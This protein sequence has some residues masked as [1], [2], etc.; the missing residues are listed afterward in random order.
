[1]PPGC[2]AALWELHDSRMP[3]TP[4]RIR[5]V[6]RA[7]MGES[8]AAMAEVWH[9]ADA[10]AEANGPDKFTIPRK[11]ARRLA[12]KKS[13]I[14]R[15]PSGLTATTLEEASQIE[16]WANAFAEETFPDFE[17]TELTLNEAEVLV[18]TQPMPSHW[19]KIPTLYDEFEE[20][21]KHV[22]QDD[23][24]ALPSEK[25][26]EYERANPS[27][28]TP[29]YK[30]IRK[31]YRI[32][33]KGQRDTGKGDGFAI[34]LKQ[35]AK[36]FEQEMLDAYARNLPIKT[37]VI[38]RLDFIPIDP[39][40]S[41]KATECE[42]VIIRT[43]YR[44]SNL[45]RSYAWDDQ[46]ALLEPVDRYDGKDGDFYLYEIWAYD[47]MRRP[48]CGYQVGT[49]STTFREDGA[50]ATV[51]LW[52]EY[53]GI[54]ELPIAFEYGDHTASTDPDRR[55]LP[56]PYP[57]LQNWRQRD[58]MLTQLGVSVDQFAYP[59][60]GQLITKESIDVMNQLEGDVD[61]EFRFE[62]NTIKPIVGQ[63]VPLN[64]ASTT[65]DFRTLL[66]ALGEL[67]KEELPSAGAFGGD[68]PTSGLDRQLTGADTEVAYA[69]TIE[70]VR[71]VKEKHARN[72]L[73]V[74][75]AL[76]KKADRPVPI[77]AVG[78]GVSPKTGKKETTW[79]P[80]E[81]PPDLCGGIWD[82]VAEFPNIPGQNLAASS[83]Y[84]EALAQKAILMREWREKGWGDR[85]PEQ[86]M[87]ER[88]LEDYY[89]SPAGQLD[90]MQSMAEEL[91]DS[92][93]Q[94]LLKLANQGK[95]TSAQGGAPT[96]VMD[97][98]TGQQPGVGAVGQTG[99]GVSMPQPGMQALAA[100]NGAAMQAD[101]AAG[102]TPSPF[103]GG[104]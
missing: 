47:E 94:E 49:R 89:L 25:R 30:R 39:T 73:M 96:A 43:L 44:R 21:D 53:P 80:I 55:S 56:M 79:T 27:E 4:A 61:L 69:G 29:K 64:S 46:H 76:G 97:Y 32:D 15:Q 57:F 41:G 26:R 93:L 78:E 5:A 67:N 81:L 11:T 54:T 50:T 90:L 14:K 58:K 98:M 36:A 13:E 16:N 82:V 31:R 60:F 22:G 37:R 28:S 40:F 85:D 2:L 92:R 63:L 100:G 20:D 104:M 84:L 68:G 62:G 23:Y 87:V 18:I 88:A 38:S 66:E 45:L 86:F 48:W 74:A 65:I 19:A 71:R 83:L 52:E 24:D 33:S 51:K 35:S 75:S 10:D 34:D 7:M 103:A 59:A 6:R 102:A 72:G 77:Y 91:N 70:G 17:V 101:A 3:R 8:K 42:G 1:M 12:A 95:I 99:T 9:E